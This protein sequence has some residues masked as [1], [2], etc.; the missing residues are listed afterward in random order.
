MARLF[1]ESGL[2]RASRGFTVTVKRLW[3]APGV[4]AIDLAFAL[5]LLLDFGHFE[6]A[7]RHLSARP[8]GIAGLGVG[9]CLDALVFYLLVTNSV[10]A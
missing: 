8:A 3:H 2:P 10:R 6:E 7:T 5:R 1:P 9:G 4:L